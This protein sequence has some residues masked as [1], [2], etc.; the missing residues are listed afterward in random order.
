MELW[1][2]YIRYSYA[3]FASSSNKH[4]AKLVL[5]TIAL[6]V[7]VGCRRATQD[8]QETPQPNSVPGQGTTT[9]PK[10][11]ET[12]PGGTTKPAASGQIPLNSCVG[13]S[14]VSENCTLVTNA[15]ACT[16]TKCSKLVVVFSGGEM[17][18][19]SGPGYKKVLEAYSANG[20][21][22]VCINYFATASGSGEVPYIDEASRID[23]AVKEATTGTWATAYWSGEYLLLQGISHG[24]TAPVIL[25][26]R[27]QLAKQ[28]HWQGSKF[29][30]GCFFDGSYNQQ[31]TANLLATGAIGGNAC[32]TP[33][34]YLRGLERYCGA[35]A[36][37][38]NCNLSSKPK[39]Q[40]D[41]IT[42]LTMNFAIKDFK[43]FECGSALPAC[44][45][46]II[47][48]A[49]VQQLCSNIAAS[50]G[51]SCNF[52]SLYNDGHLTCHANEYD[53]CRVWFEGIAP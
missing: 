12:S 44:V 7:S 53:Q 26:A 40:E 51:Y 48:G 16:Q 35:G 28:A 20:Y 6:T 29:T 39:A 41:T 37:G 22:A 43:M 1:T 49:P 27:T 31:A 47:P 18:C 45:G 4:F 19:V 5:L 3:D 36:T 8:T 17:G 15:N 52:V 24:A 50:P 30:A 32:T 38:A 21:A 23:L 10:T 14:G 33:V 2:R 34:S 42:G 13:L 25:M 46:D 11:D 9:D